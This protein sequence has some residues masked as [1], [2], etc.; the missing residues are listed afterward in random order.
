MSGVRPLGGVLLLIGGG[1]SAWR[2]WRMAGPVR[3]VI[4]GAVYV[5][6]FA[7]SHPL[8][9]VIGTWPAVFAVAVIAA[10]TSVWVGR[11]IS[12]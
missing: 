1:W 7:M 11:P 3:T 2:L 4:V 5:A 6:A 9:E 8:G 12:G 10:L